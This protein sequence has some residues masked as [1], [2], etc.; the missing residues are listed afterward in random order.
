MVGPMGFWRMAT[1]EEQG[2]P[3]ERE[4]G[5]AVEVHE[6]SW[7]LGQWARSI[8]WEDA[9]SSGMETLRLFSGSFS[10]CQCGFLSAK[11]MLQDRV[12]D[13]L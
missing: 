8:S 11:V 13:G 3:G 2:R 7:W 9:R 5:T 4:R 10:A 12:A 1:S 6:R